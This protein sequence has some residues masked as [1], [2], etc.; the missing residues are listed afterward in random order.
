MK[1]GEV[2]KATRQKNWK[3]DLKQFCH[4]IENPSQ[5]FQAQLNVVQF[6]L[7]KSKKFRSSCYAAEIDIR[8]T[9]FKIAEMLMTSCK[10]MNSI[11]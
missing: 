1:S 4:L 9:L 2:F 10:L 3:L 11:R 6:R 8:F 7:D 5:F